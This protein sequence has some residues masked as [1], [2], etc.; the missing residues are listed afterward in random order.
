LENLPTVVLLDGVQDPGN[1]GTIMRLCLGFKSGLLLVESAEPTN[2]KTIRS[3]AGAVFRVPWVRLSRR[4]AEEY[5]T[6][7]SDRTIFRLEKR[8]E[9]SPL[10]R[11]AASR[12]ALLV[13]GAEGGGI[14]LKAKGESIAVEHEP[15]LE[16]LNVSQALAI[17]LYTRYQGR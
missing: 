5:L 17:A 16:S 2:P 11:L 4:Q 9:S 12:R 15:D 1:V 14:R 3:S 7:A 13:A 8:T 6:D 10:S